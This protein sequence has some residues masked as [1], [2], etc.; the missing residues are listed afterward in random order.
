M[1]FVAV[2]PLN[3]Q[4]DTSL[5]PDGVRDIAPPPLFDVDVH[6]VN[7]TFRTLPLYPFTTLPR[8]LLLIDSNV[9]LEMVREV[10]GL[11]MR[12]HPVRVNDLNCELVSVSFFEL[13]GLTENE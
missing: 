1:P 12:E 7:V 4:D 6:V 10:V 2:H 13:I 9:T 3:V 8:P 5:V 11:V